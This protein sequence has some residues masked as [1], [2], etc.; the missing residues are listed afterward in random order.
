ML[1]LYLNIVLTYIY[2]P[3]RNAKLVLLFDILA[4]KG[5]AQYG[6]IDTSNSNIQYP[7][8]SDYFL[9]EYIGASIYPYY[10][11][12]YLYIYIYQ[13]TAQNSR[14]QVNQPSANHSLSLSCLEWEVPRELLLHRSELIPPPV[15]GFE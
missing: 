11:L 3:K 8:F 7:S 9:A 1:G 2:V 15:L 4:S 14:V 6:S 5:R 12:V 10:T 13:S